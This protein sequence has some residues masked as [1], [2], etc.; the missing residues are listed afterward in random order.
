M[1]GVGDDPVICLLMQKQGD[2]GGP[3]GLM[4]GA[5]SFSR[6]SME[7]FMEEDSVCE[8]LVLSQFVEPKITGTS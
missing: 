2:E 8:L 1:M 6:I 3:T 5:Q 4:R 7:V